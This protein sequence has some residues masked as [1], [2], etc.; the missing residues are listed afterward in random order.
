MTI[1]Q[2]AT[3]IKVSP[4]TCHKF[5][6]AGMP[7]D[8]I[9]AAKAWIKERAKAA[10]AP[11]TDTTN[12]TAKRGRKLDLECQL[13]SLRIERESSNAEF[14]EVG[15]ALRSIRLF[16]VLLLLSLKMRGDAA[17]ERLTGETNPAKVSGI[18]Q[19][20]HGSAWLEGALGMHF[21]CRE[22]RMGA[23]IAATIRS[24]FVKIDDEKIWQ[25]GQEFF[26]DA[27]KVA[28]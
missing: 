14:L 20:I 4:S 11:S 25:L 2:I 8:S 1:R 5:S 3:G 9:E 26:G 13:L 10:P 7:V 28:A 15:E 12:L 22:D 27:A 6:R 16:M 18:L 23:A 17:V 21:Q 19:D 24:E